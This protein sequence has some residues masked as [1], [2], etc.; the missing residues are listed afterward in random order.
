MIAFTQSV[1]AS[2]FSLLHASGQ[3]VF[4]FIDIVRCLFTYPLRWKLLAEQLL[5]IGSKSQTIVLITGGFTG[6]VFAAQTQFHFSDLGMSSA[7]GSVVTI[8]MLRELGPVLTA[9]MISGRV[10]SAIAAGL[11]TMK[12]TEQIDA[13]RALAVYPIQYLIVPRFLGLLISMPILVALSSAMGIVAGY[14]VACPIMGVESSYFINGIIK[15][16]TATDVWIGLIKGTLFG[17]IIALIACHK[18]L[19]AGH[20]AEGVGQATTDA[21][22]HASICCLISNFFFTFMLNMIFKS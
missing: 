3:I 10:G 11:A 18:G 9:L 1:G 21:S 6:A 22:V 13:L 2:F 15:Y 19:N 14:I 5:F 17:F 8:A 12:L 7:T 4:L 16:T 20:G